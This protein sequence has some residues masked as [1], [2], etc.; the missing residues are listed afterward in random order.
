[1]DK[2]GYLRRKTARIANLWLL[3]PL[4]TLALVQCAHDPDGPR[5]AIIGPGNQQRAVVN[6]EL[7]QTQPQRERGL[8]F[9]AKLPSDNGMLFTFPAPYHQTFWMHNTEI[10]LDM[11]FAGS[12]RRVIGIVA[13]AQPYS[14]AQLS[15]PGD[16]QYVLEV[17]GGFCKQHAI[18]AG[19]R[20][21][22]LDFT[23][24]PVQ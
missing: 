5:V 7:A 18:A 8:M 10:P 15:V 11:I 14:D 19:D 16:S 3:L 17:N 1:V 9:R 4:A 23:P 6:V 13:N 21:E 12:D 22:F 24:H 20:L 2:P